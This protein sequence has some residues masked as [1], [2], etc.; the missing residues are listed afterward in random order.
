MAA[1]DWDRERRDRPRR[2][3]GGQPAEDHTWRGMPAPKGPF[4]AS[5]AA[6]AML[7]DALDEPARRQLAR[8]ACGGVKALAETARDADTE[9]RDTRRRWEAEQDWI[10]SLDELRATARAIADTAE[11]LSASGSAYAAEMEWL[12]RVARRA[13]SAPG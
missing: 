13:G 3:H 9:R 2:E 5:F 11:R 7:V 10:L 6:I 4:R 1:R 12:A 8:A